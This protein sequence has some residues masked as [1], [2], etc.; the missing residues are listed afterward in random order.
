LVRIDQAKA[1]ADNTRSGEHDSVRTLLQDAQHDIAA[2]RTIVPSDHPVQVYLLLAQLA[3]VR[4]W[5]E[6]ILKEKLTGDMQAHARKTV[7]EMAQCRLRQYKC[8][9]QGNP[10]WRND[11]TLE[12]WRTLL[13]VPEPPVLE[14]KCTETVRCP[15]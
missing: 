11:P 6:A 12:G 10:A 9:L 1:K 8:L 7:A 13:A 15:L 4:V 3:G 2:A 5:Q 14:E